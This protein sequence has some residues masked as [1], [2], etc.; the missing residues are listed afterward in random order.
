MKKSYSPASTSAH[1]KYTTIVTRIGVLFLFIIVLS[2]GRLTANPITAGLRLSSGVSCNGFGTTFGASAVVGYG[3]HTFLLGTSI[4][5]QKPHF[6]GVQANYQYTFA[7][8]R[9]QYS[10]KPGRLALY[11][12][13]NA[14][15]SNS[16]LGKN[17]C[18]MERSAQDAEV[19]PELESIRF[20]TVEGY[21][22][23]GLK[24]RLGSYFRFGNEIGFG[25]YNVLNAPAMSYYD[26]KAVGL[27]L[28]TSLSFE[29]PL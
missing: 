25:G 12:F 19:N 26:T 24:I 21:V 8:T 18:A 17:M 28:R 22:G 10:G 6:S 3:S 9:N 23:L 13:L 1:A 5:K 14:G 20:R 27:V 15:Y 11:G 16:Y 4:Q 7:H 2:A 29:I